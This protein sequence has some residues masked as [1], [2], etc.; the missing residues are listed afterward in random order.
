MGTPLGS[1]Q[2]DVG[3][4]HV[5]DNWDKRIFRQYAQKT[6]IFNPKHKLVKNEGG[7]DENALVLRKKEAFREG[8]TRATIT[9]VKQLQGSPTH[10]N[11]TMWD[12][13]EAIDTETFRWEIQK[14]RHAV[15]VDGEIQDNRVSWNIIKTSSQLLGEWFAVRQEAAAAMHLTGFNINANRPTTE[16]WWLGDDL[17]ATWGNAPTRPDADHHLTVNDKDAED[18]TATDILDWPMI[19][20]CVALAA[21]YPQPIRPIRMYGDDYFVVFVHPYM[22]RTW[23]ESGTRWW[24]IAKAAI[25]G[26]KINGNPIIRGTVGAYE[27]CIFMVWPYL[28]PALNAAGTAVV[29]NTRSAVFCGQA[30]LLYGVAK[31]YP[32][33]NTFRKVERDKDYGDKV[34]VEAH[35]LGGLACP[36]FS[37]NGTTQRYSTIVMDGY[38]K[39]L[40]TPS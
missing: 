20:D 26:G 17:G 11:Q 1:T 14:I 31:R 7:G 39:D 29:D 18:F 40:I 19:S 15:K 24:E 25:E 34:G 9:L 21:T 5:R 6:V 30:S 23:K 4:P 33:E 38:A 3:D 35:T 37:F 16:P 22:T 13:E 32:D 28:P 2:F 8:G 10:G 27:G 12:R 36:E